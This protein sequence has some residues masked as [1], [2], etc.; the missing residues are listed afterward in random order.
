MSLVSAREYSVLHRRG[1][2]K[3]TMTDSTVASTRD[4]ISEP[5]LRFRRAASVAC[6]EI[7]EE[8]VLLAGRTGMYFSVNAV[9]QHVWRQLAIS[10]EFSEIRAA[11]AREFEVEESVVAVDLTEFLRQLVKCD[12]V[13]VERDPM[14]EAT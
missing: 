13:L 14:A 4:S 12:L 3:G 8:S 2:G 5:S 10:A 1:E 9:G 6:A 11:V 7:G